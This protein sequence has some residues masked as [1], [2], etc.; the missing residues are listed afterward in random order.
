MVICEIAASSGPF[1]R[2]GDNDEAG[3][4]GWARY[5]NAHGGLLGHPVR[6]VKENDESDPTL[7]RLPRGRVRDA[8]ARALHL[9]AGGEC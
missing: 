8:G 6:F 9:R 4:A 5:V 1:A 7:C 3:A 2:L